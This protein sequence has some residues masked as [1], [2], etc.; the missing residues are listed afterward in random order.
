M[1]M[2][3]SKLERSLHEDVLPWLFEQVEEFLLDDACK[4][5]NTFEM[6]E[7]GIRAPQYGHHKTLI[8]I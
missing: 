6:I 1:G 4:I 7:H 8:E 3:T 2:V 5:K